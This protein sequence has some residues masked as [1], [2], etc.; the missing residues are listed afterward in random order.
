MYTPNKQNGP[1]VELFRAGYFVGSTLLGSIP[2]TRHVWLQFFSALREIKAGC[3]VALQFGGDATNSS[4]TTRPFVLFSLA[5]L[6]VPDPAKLISHPQVTAPFITYEVTATI[7]SSVLDGS[8]ML[9]LKAVTSDVGHGLHHVLRRS[10]RTVERVSRERSFGSAG[11]LLFALQQP[12]LDDLMTPA[13]ASILDFR[14]ANFYLL[15][16]DRGVRWMHGITLNAD[17]SPA[18]DDKDP[19]YLPP[20]PGSPSKYCHS[21]TSG[22]E[23]RFL[24]SHRQLS[25]D[26][27]PLIARKL[28]MQ[29]TNIACSGTATDVFAAEK[30]EGFT[31]TVDSAGLPWALDVADRFSQSHDCAS[32]DGL[33]IQSST[34]WA[35]HF[36]YVDQRPLEVLRLRR[37]DV[38][39]AGPRINLTLPPYKPQKV[40]LTKSAGQ[41]EASIAVALSVR[42]AAAESAFEQEV[43]A[44]ARTFCEDMMWLTESAHIT[45]KR[46]LAS[47][48][49]DSLAQASKFLSEAL[50]RTLKIFDDAADIVDVLVIC[51][52]PA[53]PKENVTC[54]AS[55]DGD[56]VATTITNDAPKRP[57]VANETVTHD[58]SSQPVIAGRPGSGHATTQSGS[59]MNSAMLEDGRFLGPLVRNVYTRTIFASKGCLSSTLE[60]RTGFGS[61][62]LSLQFAGAAYRAVTE[63]ADN[64]IASRVLSSFK[65]GTG[66]M[67]L[68]HHEIMMGLAENFQGAE[69]ITL[70]LIGSFGS[71]INLGACELFLRYRPVNTGNL[72]I[73]A[74]YPSALRSSK[75]DADYPDTKIQIQLSGQATKDPLGQ[76]HHANV[77]HSLISAQ[78]RML[79]LVTPSLG[80]FVQREQYQPWADAAALTILNNEWLSPFMRTAS[81]RIAKVHKGVTGKFVGT[82]R[83]K[84]YADGRVTLEDEH[85]IDA[86]PSITAPSGEESNK[87]ELPDGL[88]GE[89]CDQSNLVD[90]GVGSVLPP[91]LP[92]KH[93]RLTKY[94][95]GEMRFDTKNLMP[96][97]SSCNTLTPLT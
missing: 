90:S 28:G 91:H 54:R 79:D 66:N 50:L 40:H 14:S 31:K 19:V 94:P 38:R 74:L 88:G 86:K 3:D 82:A 62:S 45:M 15:G 59:E 64:E 12:L 52:C 96:Y 80:H 56:T 65:R 84:R 2:G 17:G 53:D 37:L 30:L 27:W 49:F 8:P 57:P 29:I 4:T 70:R 13:L 18:E 73:S 22:G 23:K 93:Y 21:M 83:A 55:W 51:K 25:V 87:Q 95:T 16:A 44:S 6:W 46:V 34:D 72:L 71:Q 33:V 77:R 89:G 69:N 75:P 42:R 11:E 32:I 43:P 35:A 67:P 97:V 9:D 61:Y 10:M 68:A 41:S 76:E 39:E 78:I 5:P 26:R 24:T 20:V 58:R 92:L 81:V 63:L 85:D 7:K 36:D 1:L 60:D 48:Q 47:M